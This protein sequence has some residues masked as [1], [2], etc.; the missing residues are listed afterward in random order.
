MQAR[1]GRA[2]APRGLN[3]DISSR[4]GKS[5]QR[6]KKKMVNKASLWLDQPFLGF[7]YHNL[8]DLLLDQYLGNETPLDLNASVLK[9]SCGG[10][11]EDPTLGWSTG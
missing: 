3:G 1:T 11:A 6:R 10:P 9:A 2:K 7:I 8:E 4:Y 5:Y